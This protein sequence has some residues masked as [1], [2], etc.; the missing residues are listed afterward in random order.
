M[1]SAQSATAVAPQ[2]K[3]TN[4]P[5][6]V[7]HDWKNG[8]P[9]VA[10]CR[11]IKADGTWSDV[12]VPPPF[13][14]STEEGGF[15]LKTLYKLLDVTL[16]DIVHCNGGFLMVVDDEGLMKPNPVHNKE[17]SR[18]LGALN[19]KQHAMIYGD[20]LFCHSSFVG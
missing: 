12:K 19:G 7:D 1:S 17:A 5:K 16:I 15:E 2:A 6:A 11:L 18:L 9:P 14:P 13:N 10:I 20:V 8:K 4:V 3:E